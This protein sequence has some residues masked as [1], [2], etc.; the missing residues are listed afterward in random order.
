M[1]CQAI[2]TG[3]ILLPGFVSEHCRDLL[4]H[5]LTKNPTNR[6]SIADI[7][8]HPW[9]CHDLPRGAQVMNNNP[10]VYEPQPGLQSED[11][12]RQLCETA[13]VAPGRKLTK[14]YS[15]LDE[16]RT[17]ERDLEQQFDDVM[18]GISASLQRS[19]IA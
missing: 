2:L 3:P 16:D 10:L 18:E 13:R 9:Y 19:Q 12:I 4:A 6:F 8:Q 15:G 17:V 1:S 7:Q 5:L 11:E 14:I